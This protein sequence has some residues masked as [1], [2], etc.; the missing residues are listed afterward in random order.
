MDRRHFLRMSILATSASAA[1]PS[2][3]FASPSGRRDVAVPGDGPYGPLSETPDANGLLLPAGFTSRIVA[4]GGDPVGDTTFNWHPFPDGAATFDDGEG[5]Y[6]YVCN[7]EVFEFM[8]PASGGVSAI[9]F[10]AD[11]EILDAYRILEGSNSNCAGGPTP[12]GTWLSGEENFAG[13]GR[14]W[15]CDPTGAKEAVAH[16]AMGLWA[17]E[18]AA[19]DPVNK[20]VYMT[21]DNGAGRFYRFTPS[22]YPDL[23]A[24]VLEACIV[25]ADGAVTWGVVS[26]PS[27]ATTPTREQVPGATIFPGNEGCWYHEG[28]VFFTSKVDHSVHEIDIATQKYSLVWKGDPDGLGTEGA[29][30]SHVDNIT[31]DAGSGDLI[32][33]EDGGNM[34]L[35][36]ITPDGVVAPFVRVVGAGHELSEMTGP[37]F[38]P[39]RDRLYFSSQRG[40]STRDLAEIIPGFAAIDTI[41]AVGARAGVTFEITGPF[42]GAV[43]PEVVTTDAPTSVPAPTTTLALVAPSEGT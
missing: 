36:I 15:E 31:V 20:T 23:S 33:A 27:G 18:A 6:Y 14:I 7:S 35:C 22:A 13:T 10:G 4:I 30:L 29:V 25:D 32:V 42:R 21:E 34:E 17:H 38:S 37:V 40:P 11:G 24:G 9:H 12:W 1:V 16:T 41:G 28:K 19:V 8:A 5:G 2:A 43:V 3:V 26:D 39:N